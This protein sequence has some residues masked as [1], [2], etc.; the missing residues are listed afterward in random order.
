MRI[1]TMRACGSCRMFIPPAFI[2][3][4]ASSTHSRFQSRSCRTPCLCAVTECQRTARQLQ[5]G[6]HQT[7]AAPASLSSPTLIMAR[8]APA[9]DTCCRKFLIGLG[10]CLLLP[11]FAGLVLAAAPFFVFYKLCD[12]CIN[13]CRDNPHPDRFWDPS[14]LPRHSGRCC[15][16]GLCGAEYFN[17]FIDT[18]DGQR[19][20]VDVYLPEAHTRNGEKVAAVL[21]QARYCRSFKLRWPLSLIFPH[22]N[23]SLVANQF[24]Y[25][26]S[27]LN[28]CIHDLF[29]RH[30]FVRSGGMAFV[31]VDIRGTGA[32]AG[33][34]SSLWSE[35]ERE[36]SIAVLDWI[37]QQPWSNGS[38][39]LWGLSYDAT[40]AMFTA[41]SGHPAVKC[42]VCMFPFWDFYKSIAF[43]GGCRN[44][45]FI[46]TWQ[47]VND[48]LVPLIGAS[49]LVDRSGAAGLPQDRSDGPIPNTHHI[50]TNC[51]HI[52]V[53]HE[54]CAGSGVTPI[55]GHE[56]AMESVREVHCT[57]WSHPHSHG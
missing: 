47:A 17:L 54:W 6:L 36:D 51:A 50:V 18:P 5:R 26:P 23:F 41:A 15:K 14:E 7:L 28:K 11:L 42:S 53:S 35:R 34:F 3:V 20:A 8:P 9:K 27:D 25:V 21:H 38:V 33:R 52:S 32:S 22:S 1:D 29:V 13:K 46:G 4:W 2:V 56:E 55:L 44:K 57:N 12:C 37:T 39:G 48:C 19:L 49:D 40:A 31:S 16:I 30:D 43:P 24:G 10:V 45:Y